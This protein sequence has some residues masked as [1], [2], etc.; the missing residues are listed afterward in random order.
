MDRRELAVSLLKASL[1]CNFVEK[2]RDGSTVRSVVFTGDTDFFSIQT[3]DIQFK[4]DQGGLSPVGESGT[5][6]ASYGA[7][8]VTRKQNSIDL[9]CKN[10]AKCALVQNDSVLFD[11]QTFGLSPPIFS[12]N[13]RTLKLCNEQS[14][15]NV[16]LAMSA[17]TSATAKPFDDAP[18][19][20]AIAG[21]DDADQLRAFTLNFPWSPFLG[22]AEKRLSQAKPPMKPRGPSEWQIVP[23]NREFF[24]VQIAHG[25]SGP[26]DKLYSHA[27]DFLIPS[28]LYADGRVGKWL[29]VHDEK[30][31]TAFVA[32]S[33]LIEANDHE[34]VQYFEIDRRQT[35]T[36]L[37]DAFR[38][39]SDLV[40]GGLYTDGCDMPHVFGAQLF[41]SVMNSPIYWAVGDV[42]T[43]STLRAPRTRIR[44]EVS[45]QSDIDFPG[46]GPVTSVVLKSISDGS[47]DERSLFSPDNTIWTELKGSPGNY[48]AFHL[49]F[50][51]TEAMSYADE[52]WRMFIANYIS[53]KADHDGY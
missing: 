40:K 9:Q 42:V 34:R 48:A 15:A 53:E 14:A 29:R 8:D 23:E 4:I 11:D 20:A 38:Q 35:R 19:W 49:C 32:R 18:M 16:E 36:L 39:S 52:A 43:R 27:I 12:S 25:Y 50:N 51:Q 7:L 6:K 5:F 45:E 33:Q 10:A 41:R 21:S 26:D 1:N 28:R 30:D 47:S 31:R 3:K 24:P 17:L 22:E 13:G 2:N 37:F 46:V 44:Y